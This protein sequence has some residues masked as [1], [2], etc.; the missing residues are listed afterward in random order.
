MPH[1]PS[2]ALAL[3]EALLV[4]MVWA[5]SFIL[6]KIA[7]TELGPLTIGG[8]RY[9]IGFACLLPFLRRRNF[10]L[11]RA[12]WLPMVPCFGHCAFCLLLQSLS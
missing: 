4:S 12:Q 11:T 6:V 2:R 3:L 9:F 7:L 8:L 10:S 1:L 5:S